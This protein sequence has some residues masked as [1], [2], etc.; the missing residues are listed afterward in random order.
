MVEYT[1][2]EQK[3]NKDFYMKYKNVFDLINDDIDKPRFIFS[4]DHLYV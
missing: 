1:I 2:S 4:Q 3:W